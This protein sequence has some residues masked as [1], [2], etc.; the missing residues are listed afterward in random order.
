MISTKNAF[1]RAFSSLFILTICC[2]SAYSQNTITGVLQ[3]ESSKKPVQYANVSLLRQS[4]SVLVGYT[5]ADDK[6][7]FQL[8]MIPNG[9]YRLIVY[10]IGY[11]N[12]EQQ[13]SV[14][15]NIDLGTIPLKAGTTTI[16]EVVVK[17]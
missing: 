1:I 6:G 8:Q 11:E 13:L 5:A 16:G 12:H 15:K 10:F 7:A 2:L 4:D 14:V 3:D 17:G 9:E